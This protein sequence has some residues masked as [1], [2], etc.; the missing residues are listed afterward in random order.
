MKTIKIFLKKYVRHA[1]GDEYICT[2]I[3]TIDVPDDL[4]L[5]DEVAVLTQL[6]KTYPELSSEYP[7]S[8]YRFDL[9]D[10]Q[11]TSKRL[12]DAI[13]AEFAKLDL[14]EVLS[15]SVT[16]NDGS[17]EDGFAIKVGADSDENDDAIGFYCGT[18]DDFRALFSPSANADFVVTGFVG[19]RASYAK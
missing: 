1:D 19:E 9:V 3:A 12:D 16:W 2:N 15:C 4:D 5:H 17:T 6:H 14:P 18:S 10:V 7:S 8:E 13:E 11:D